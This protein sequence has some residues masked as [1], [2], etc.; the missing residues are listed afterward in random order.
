MN[1]KKT[2]SP[3]AFVI[4]KEIFESQ[5]LKIPFLSYTLEKIL[6]P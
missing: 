1:G 6:Q 3:Y 5:A 2:D 4:R